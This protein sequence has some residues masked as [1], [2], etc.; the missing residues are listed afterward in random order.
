VFLSKITAERVS[1]SNVFKLIDDYVIQQSP[2]KIRNGDKTWKIKNLNLVSPDQMRNFVEGR[3]G[4]NSL[5]I[6]SVAFFHS[7]D[8]TEESN[9][10]HQ[11][12]VREL[13]DGLM[14]KYGYSDEKT[15][16][17]KRTVFPETFLNARRAQIKAIFKGYVISESPK[18]SVA[19]NQMEM[20]RSIE[21]KKMLKIKAEMMSEGFSIKIFSPKM[22]PEAEN[23][24][25]EKMNNPA[26]F[27]HKTSAVDQLSNLMT[28]VEGSGLGTLMIK[29]F[30]NFIHPGSHYSVRNVGNHAVTEITLPRIGQE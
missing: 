15:E 12:A 22:E 23:R 21:S 30:L 26:T 29:R 27:S 3:L 1:L 28:N 10:N 5:L 17:F 18:L 14:K 9:V 25:N 6:R 7:Y 19:I 13:F 8:L 24:L 16:D 20:D 4:Y 2:A 11:L